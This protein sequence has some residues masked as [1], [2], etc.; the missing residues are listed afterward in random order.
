MT[1]RQRQLYIIFTHALIQSTIKH[2]T[3]PYFLINNF[4]LHEKKSARYY[5]KILPVLSFPPTNGWIHLASHPFLT[6]LINR[7]SAIPKCLGNLRYPP[8]VDM[9]SSLGSGN[10][11]LAAQVH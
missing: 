2:S 4:A 5:T 6:T 7:D 1:L 3:T 9:L 8:S 11:P 10:L